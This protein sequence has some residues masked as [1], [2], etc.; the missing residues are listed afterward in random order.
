MDKN[1]VLS[2]S[3]FW[4]ILRRN[5]V[6]VNSISGLFR[7]FLASR[8]AIMSKRIH[9]F[10]RMPRFVYDNLIDLFYKYF[11]HMLTFLLCYCGILRYSN[12]K[13]L[14]LIFLTLTGMAMFK[15][16]I[17]LSDFDILWGINISWL[18]MAY[19]VKR[20]QKLTFLMLFPR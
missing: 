3:V 4:Y 16:D 7:N 5:H 12:G 2:P 18:A 1:V 8:F 6:Q 19:T 14:L 20:H 9:R 17:H 11:L 13:I 10:L 15:R